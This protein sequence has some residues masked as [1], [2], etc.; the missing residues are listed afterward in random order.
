[1]IKC[2]NQAIYVD[3]DDINIYPVRCEVHK[4]STDIKL[5]HKRCSNCEHDLYFPERREFC[6]NCGLYREKRLYHF[7]EQMV[8]EFLK[9]NGIQFIY[10]K[11]VDINGSMF[12][13]DFLIT[14]KFGY[15]VVEVD[16]YQ[17]KSSDYNIKHEEYRM[18]RIY[19]DIQNHK[20]LN[21]ELLFIRFNPDNYEG[22][23]INSKQRLEYLYT[24]I[25]YFEIIDTIGVS[26][27]KIY[28]YYD[29]FAGNNIKIEPISLT[30]E[31]INDEWTNEP[32]FDYFN[33]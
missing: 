9:S 6:M 25:K 28:L 29:G 18:R 26:I 19:F 11:R 7:K 31:N 24:L 2:P 32:N 15:I 16:E 5:T 23:N 1:M 10:D 20:G 14:T 33:E 4:L 12:R 17:H 13:P 21:K 3:A 22:Q 27:G 8:K 30:N